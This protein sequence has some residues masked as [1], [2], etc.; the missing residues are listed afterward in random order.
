MIKDPLYR[1]TLLLS[2]LIM[3]GVCG[4]SQDI[5]VRPEPPRLVNDL[6][7]ILSPEEVHRLETQLV[8]FNDS[9]AT[10]IVVITVKSL[11]GYDKADFSYRIGEQWGVGQKGKNNGLVVLVKPKYKNEPGEAYIAV[12]YGL[13]SVI[14]DAVSIRII[15][16]EMIPLFEQEDYYGGIEAGTRVL[17]DLARKEYPATE[18]M[19]KT[20]D[21][22]YT[23]LIPVI[24][25]IAIFFL[26]RMT[27][28]KSY[29]VGKSL[30]FWTAF[31]LLGSL[32]RGGHSSSWN[33][34]TSGGSGF[35]GGGGGGFG[36]FGGGSFG[37]G[38]AGGSW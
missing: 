18:Y 7:G 27:R 29:S 21:S 17:M 19:K 22:P 3:S 16:H 9:T 28:A 10:Q 15:N 33:N 1:T 20:E 34:F 23:L 5:P 31:F 36:G 14:P 2:I 26:I 24:I 32:G 11:N 35:G 30:P 38:G 13:E 12:G 4:V 8:A 37:G 25:L 6:A